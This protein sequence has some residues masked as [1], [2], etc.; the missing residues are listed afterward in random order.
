MPMIVSLTGVCGVR[1]VWI[2]IVFNMERYHM[3]ETVYVSYPISWIITTLIH[4]VTY[5][6]VRKRVMARITGREAQN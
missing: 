4:V 3:V 2:A 6:V 5:L 1:L